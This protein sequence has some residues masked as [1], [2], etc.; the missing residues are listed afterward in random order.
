MQP[1][2]A[3]MILFMYSVG[4]TYAFI[5]DKKKG[6]SLRGGLPLTLGIAL[7]WIIVSVASDG[8]LAVGIPLFVVFVFVA[9]PLVSV[10]LGV[11]LGSVGALLPKGLGWTIVSSLV[12][13]CPVAALVVLLNFFGQQEQTRQMEM[14]AQQE[15]FRLTNVEA[16]FAGVPVTLPAAPNIEVFHDCRFENRPDLRN[17]LTT[18]RDADGIRE[19]NGLPQPPKLNEIII[20]PSNRWVAHWCGLRPDLAES[21]WCA[22]TVSHEIRLTT[23]PGRRDST[24]Y[25]VEDPREDLIIQCV[26]NGHMCEAHYEVAPSV[27]GSVLMR[28]PDPAYVLAFASLGKSVTEKIWADITR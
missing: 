20:R 2:P 26:R 14:R 4:V 19:Q 25:E 16:I 18:F 9:I 6:R 24:W 15:A 11:F 17:C 23:E 5:L 12:V 3:Y 22:E 1:I 10:S 28:N 7:I 27:Y 13:A 21:F 8:G